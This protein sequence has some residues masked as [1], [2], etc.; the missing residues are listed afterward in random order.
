MAARGTKKHWC[1]KV[2]CPLSQSI[3]CGY[4]SADRICR[5]FAP[6]D[7][8]EKILAKLEEV[9]V[10]LEKDMESDGWTGR[11]ITLKYKLDT[12]QG[13]SDFVG[14]FIQILTPG[15]YQCLPEP[16]LW[17]SGCQQKK[18]SSRYVCYVFI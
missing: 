16:N 11:T 14:A 8:M 12:Y 15:N 5:T 10:E 9:A 2:S 17:I 13:M 6:L 1:R 7:D 18:N 4:T 3:P